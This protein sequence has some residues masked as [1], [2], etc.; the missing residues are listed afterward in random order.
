MPPLYTYS[1]TRTRGIVA[2]YEFS[3]KPR[4]STEN[5]FGGRARVWGGQFNEIRGG[6]GGRASSVFPSSVGLLPI[7]I[8]T[9]RGPPVPSTASNNRD[10]DSGNDTPLIVSTSPGKRCGGE[11]SD[12]ITVEP[13]AVFHGFRERRIFG[14]G[15]FGEDWQN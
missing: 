1:C 9:R 11:L 6:R 12:W 15:S 5:R 13:R 3:I 14:F 7:E 8:D 2:R 10:D 4:I